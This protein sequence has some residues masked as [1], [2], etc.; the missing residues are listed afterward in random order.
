[1]LSSTFLAILF[2][3]GIETSRDWIKEVR[4]G[5]QSTRGVTSTSS[6]FT[7]QKLYELLYVILKLPS[8]HLLLTCG[9]D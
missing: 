7:D 6:M 4:E 5:L 3:D 8:G 9:I 1:M 2:S